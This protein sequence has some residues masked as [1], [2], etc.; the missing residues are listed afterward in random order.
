MPLG[1]GEL[2]LFLGTRSILRG[3]LPALEDLEGVIDGLGLGNLL[4]IEVAA[5]DQLPAG[6]LLIPPVT[7][8]SDFLS[9]VGYG[10]SRELLLNRLFAAQVS[11]AANGFGLFL[12]RQTLSLDV[13]LQLGFEEGDRAGLGGEDAG[14]SIWRYLGTFETDWDAEHVEG[15]ETLQSPFAGD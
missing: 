3:N 1:N 12:P 10:G 8:A 15:S 11:E 4:I 7:A 9:D 13:L 14:G 5:D 6:F 2:T